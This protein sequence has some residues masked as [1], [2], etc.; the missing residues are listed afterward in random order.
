MSIS[1]KNN[2]H[3]IEVEKMNKLENEK[4][5]NLTPLANSIATVENVNVSDNDEKLKNKI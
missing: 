2:D 5:K 4:E 3:G 1:E